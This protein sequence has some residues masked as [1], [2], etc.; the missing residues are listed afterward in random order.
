ML[1]SKFVELIKLWKFRGFKNRHTLLIIQEHIPSI[2]NC[3]E[4]FC[5]QSFAIKSL[6]WDLVID[7]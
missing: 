6:C 5:S 1:Y 3:S 7:I 2:S 4:K